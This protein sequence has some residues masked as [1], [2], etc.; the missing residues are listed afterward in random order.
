MAETGWTPL[1]NTLKSVLPGG[2]WRFVRRVSS[3]V[4]TPFRFSFVT[5]HFKSCLK[6]ARVRGPMA[7]SI[8]STSIW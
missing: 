5:G 6:T 3:A 4:L 1:A 7:A 8:R 2:I